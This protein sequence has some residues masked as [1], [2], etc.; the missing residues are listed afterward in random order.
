MPIFL[1]LFSFLNAFAYDERPMFYVQGEVRIMSYWED[2]TQISVVCAFQKDG[3]LLFY[4]FQEKWYAPT[5]CQFKPEGES[6]IV[7]DA[8]DSYDKKENYKKRITK[9]NDTIVSYVEVSNWKQ[10]YQLD[11][12]G[13]VTTITSYGDNGRYSVERIKYYGD[14]WNPSNSSYYY[15]NG[16]DSSQESS[17]FE[18]LETD[19][20]GNWTK[21]KEYRGND[22]KPI[23]ATR[24]IQYYTDALKEP[25]TRNAFLYK[26]V[27]NNE[28][29]EGAR[30]V[31]VKKNSAAVYSVPEKDAA[32]IGRTHKDEC[33]SAYE[34]Q[35]GY[36]RIQTQRG[37]KS[38]SHD[39]I[40]GGWI[41]KKDVRDFKESDYK[42]QIYYCKKYVNRDVILRQA[43]KDG[44]LTGADMATLK[45][46]EAVEVQEFL[47]DGKYASILKWQDGL[48]RHEGYLPM[49]ALSDWVANPKDPR[50]VNRGGET[51][52]K[53]NTTQRSISAAGAY[54]KNSFRADYEEAVSQLSNGFV[55]GTGL[56]DINLSLNALFVLALM[57]LSLLVVTLL[58]FLFKPNS[59]AK[60]NGV[61]GTLS[62][63][64]GGPLVAF[65]YIMKGTT[66]VSFIDILIIITTMIS[67]YF[68]MRLHLKKNICDGPKPRNST[69]LLFLLFPVQYLIM[70]LYIT[71]P[72]PTLFKVIGGLCLLQAIIVLIKYGN[73]LGT[74][75]VS[76]I[77][78]STVSTFTLSLL[79]IYIVIPA[80]LIGILVGAGHAMTEFK[81]DRDYEIQDGEV[82]YKSGEGYDWHWDDRHE[83][84]I[85]DRD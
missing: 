74:K 59:L 35:D 33:F 62:V 5:I 14:S 31:I 22:R 43:Y 16:K 13:R 66:H 19:S 30:D 2:E 54:P 61:L 79:A 85:K 27:L 77:L 52:S 58:L 80:V 6:I 60:C 41:R 34:E 57:G 28:D 38:V 81:A 4:K 36:Y 42:K 45:A 78:I 63:Y 47:G 12:L 55:A 49:N 8:S 76:F 75:V 56:S 32:V 65:F 48:F 71:I 15:K 26:A 67:Y 24:V 3:S 1:L 46:G 21:R 11:V 23:V 17:R 9:T 82:F 73:K 69:A 70:H 84:R 18:V 64:L 20:N 51:V 72:F 40:E 50:S 39:R 37:H 83:K 68:V 29:E 44:T 53:E 10:E 7:S 25:V